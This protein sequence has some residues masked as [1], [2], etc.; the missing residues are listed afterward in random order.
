[1]GVPVCRD[2]AAVTSSRASSGAMPA[3]L[4]RAAVMP[5]WSRTCDEAEQFAQLRR[6]H[7]LAGGEVGVEVD[8]GGHDRLGD[9]ELAG[10]VPVGGDVQVDGEPGGQGLGE[11]RAVHARVVAGDDVEPVDGLHGFVAVGGDGDGAAA[12]HGRVQ[13][14]QDAGR[15]EGGVVD[16]QHPPLAH[17]GD[18]G[19]VDELVAAAGDRVV[20]AEEVVDDGVAGAGD[21]EQVGERGLDHGG[22]AGAGRPVQQ[23]RHLLGRGAARSSSTSQPL[24]SRRGWYSV[25]FGRGTGAGR[26]CRPPPALPPER[27]RGAAGGRVPAASMPAWVIWKRWC[28]SRWWVAC[29]A[30]AIFFSASNTAPEDGAPIARVIS[31]TLRIWSGWSA[32]CRATLR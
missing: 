3:R 5:R 31:P 24:P 17:R 2:R 23:H 8:R 10:E 1:M 18:E 7:G 13:H 26:D 16:Q 30:A 27:V 19:P 15:D 12:V 22:L 6:P 14:G 20:G 21:G 28:G 9:A 4:A 32:R 29:P 11:H 25:P